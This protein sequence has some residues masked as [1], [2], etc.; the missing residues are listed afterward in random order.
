MPLERRDVARASW[1]TEIHG[2]WCRCS[3]GRSPPTRRV[4]A[5]WT[6]SAGATARIPTRSSPA[7]CRARVGSP[8]AIGSGAR[9]CLALQTAAPGSARGRR[10]DPWSAP[11]EPART[12]RSSTR[13][14]A[15]RAA[16]DAALGDLRAADR[17]R[18]V[19][20]ARSPRTSPALLR[21]P[22]ARARGLHDRRVR[23]RTRPHRTTSRPIAC[24]EPSDALVLDFGGVLDGYYSD[25]TR[26]LAVGEPTAAAR[27]GPR[28][29]ARR[30][31]RRARSRAPG[32]RDPRRSIE[33]RRAVIDAAGYGE[34]FFHRTGHGI[35]LE[36]HEP[37]YADGRRRDRARAR[38]DLQRRARDLPR[39]AGSGCGS[40]T[41][42]PSRTTGSR[43]STGRRAS[44]SSSS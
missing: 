34:R 4:P 33:P 2:S 27:R 39:R 7:G 36:V 16:A 6:S 41:S 32:R 14:A 29:R 18:V 35:G 13:S 10:H 9:T 43:S 11:C 20:N 21:R 15:P 8:S 30:T 5:S 1:P 17:S 26:T 24:I 19:G 28:R 22:R 44:C 37:P 31:G 25:T 3:S 42:W 38:H 40:R 23:G 12:P